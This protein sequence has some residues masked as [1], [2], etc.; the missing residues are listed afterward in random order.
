[1]EECGQW[2]VGG[3]DLVAYSLVGLGGLG[4]LAA[5]VARADHDRARITA[6]CEP[7]AETRM[8][9]DVQRRPRTTSADLLGQCV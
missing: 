4:R 9:A 8:H 3:A 6:V 5:E 1:M 2:E 7:A